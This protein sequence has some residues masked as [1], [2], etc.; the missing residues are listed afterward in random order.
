MKKHTS[1]EVQ[2]HD[3]NI[4]SLSTPLFWRNKVQLPLLLIIVYFFTYLPIFL[5]Y[6]VSVMSPQNLTDVKFL[7]SILGIGVASI[8]SYGLVKMFDGYPGVGVAKYVLPSTMLC[9]GVLA[10]FMF[11][12]RLEYSRYALGSA[13]LVSFFWI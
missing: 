7:P 8:A 3:F 4:T 10:N 12:S 5:D 11:I 9:F 1:L 2:E 13:I 6:N